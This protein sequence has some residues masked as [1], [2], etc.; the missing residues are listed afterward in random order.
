MAWHFRAVRHCVVHNGGLRVEDSKSRVFCV[1]PVGCSGGAAPGAFQL[2]EPRAGISRRYPSKDPSLS[3]SADELVGGMV[4]RPVSSLMVNNLTQ[5]MIGPLLGGGNRCPP[6][7][8]CKAI[9]Y[10][11]R[12]CRVTCQSINQHEMTSCVCVLGRALFGARRRLISKVQTHV[13]I[14]GDAAL[15]RRT[16]PIYAPEF[17]RAF[18]LFATVVWSMFLS[19][20]WGVGPVSAAFLVMLSNQCC[21]LR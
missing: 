1:Y 10:R 13:V 4:V 9:L 15:R 8:S 17:S 14:K 21:H 20:F 16:F 12:G 11:P 19:R 5:M 7:Y 2:P 18:T 3:S 6:Y